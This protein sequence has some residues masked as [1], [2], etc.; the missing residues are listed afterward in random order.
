MLLSRAALEKHK[1][2]FDIFKHQM[3][4]N[5]VKSYVEN[6]QNYISQYKSP[7]SSDGSSVPE[8]CEDQE[9]LSS[10]A[11]SASISEIIRR[12]QSHSEAAPLSSIH[13]QEQQSSSFTRKQ[14]LLHS[15]FIDRNKRSASLHSVH[16][17]SLARQKRHK[18]L[19]SSS[20]SSSA[21]AAEAHALNKIPPQTKPSIIKKATH[22]MH[23]LQ[24]VFFFVYVYLIN[25]S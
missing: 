17:N 13:H 16:D 23:L 1:K 2:D 25:S 15:S 18:S 7:D 3:K 22:G 19:S 8:S 20:S 24:V 4:L 10:N 11:F 6:Q 21:A 9:P 5:R 14:Y 12:K